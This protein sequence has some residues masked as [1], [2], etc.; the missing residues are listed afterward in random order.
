MAREPRRPQPADRRAGPRR[1]QHGSVGAPQPQPDRGQLFARQANERDA[2][3]RAQRQDDGPIRDLRAWGLAGDRPRAHARCARRGLDPALTR[4]CSARAIGVR[5]PLDRFRLDRLPP[6][7]GDRRPSALAPS[8]RHAPLVEGRARGPGRDALPSRAQDACAAHRVAEARS[9]RG[10]RRHR[11]ERGR[12][13]KSRR[14]PRGRGRAIE[15]ERAA[16]RR[17]HRA[18]AAHRGDPARRLPPRRGDADRG[19]GVREH[20]ALRRPQLSLRDARGHARRRSR[21]H[22]RAAAGLRHARW[23][24]G[25]GAVAAGT[26]CRCLRARAPR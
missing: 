5:L 1:R 6:P 9:G 20:R 23:R 7:A 2:C 8:R 19:Y 16:R 21:H 22:Q 17:R 4:P 13:I 3:V 10:R 18:L 26:P 25:R 14:A 24:R 11:P 12:Q 15:R